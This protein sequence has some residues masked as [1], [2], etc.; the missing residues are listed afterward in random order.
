MSNRQT[1]YKSA[2]KSQAATPIDPTERLILRS[3][4]TPNAIAARAIVRGGTGH[5]YWAAFPA[6]SQQQIES[7]AKAIHAALYEPPLGDQ[8]LK[9]LDLPVAGRGYSALPFVY[10]LVNW[11]NDIPDL[12]KSK[13]QL[14]S[15]PDGS[16]TISYL[17]SV[18]NSVALITGTEMKSLGLHPVVYFYTRGGDFQPNAFIA[19]AAFVRDLV[20][21][22]RL[23]QFTEV[24]SRV[25]DFLL[26]HKEYITLIIKRTG[27]G[28]RSLGRI[29]RYLE[30]LVN[31]YSA[32]KTDDD[33]AAKLQSDPEF[34]FLL[35]TVRIPNIR[36]GENPTRRF[37]RSTKSASFLETATKS[38]I[39]CGVCGALVHRNSMQFD[40]IDAARDGGGTDV[41]N[42]Q[43]T[44]PYCN[45]AKAV[46]ENS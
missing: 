39:R 32:G 26:A 22:G 21:K 27:A 45:S 20:N 43:V 19:T 41:R 13:T 31:E 36:D 44:H 6:A 18:G 34:S 28:R 14:D 35:P 33:V 4:N 46:L 3:R 12:S 1:G 5:K 17:K 25:E 23:K 42:A 7:M 29:V 10:E 11:S 38:A 40:H 9:T 24:R 37:S 16:G 2:K 30:L 8:P 15:D